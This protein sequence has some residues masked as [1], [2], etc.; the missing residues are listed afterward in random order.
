MSEDEYQ[1]KYNAGIVMTKKKA[2]LD[3]DRLTLILE[4]F[5]DD[6][7]WLWG[8]DGREWVSKIR[9]IIV[10]WDADEGGILIGRTFDLALPSLEELDEGMRVTLIDDDKMTVEDATTAIQ[11][12]S[13][14]QLHFTRTSE[15]CVDLQR[16][17]FTI[18]LLTETSFL[19]G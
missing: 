3:C 8:D 6:K 14:A 9:A 13:S 19:V 4:E 2:R 5:T 10:P 16:F 12:V 18:R 1:K 11:F 7:D 17:I 15:Q